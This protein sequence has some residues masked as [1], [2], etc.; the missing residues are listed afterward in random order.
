MQEKKALYNSKRYYI[1]SSKYLKPYGNKVLTS[2]TKDVLVFSEVARGVSSF[3]PA[4][5]GAL[6]KTSRSCTLLGKRGLSSPTNACRTK[7]G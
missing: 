5:T 6:L 7:G 1:Y 4:R 2:F 3:N